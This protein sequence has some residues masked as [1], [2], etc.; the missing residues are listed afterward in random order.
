MQTVTELVKKEINVEKG[1]G[2]P[3]KEKIGNLAMEILQKGH[4]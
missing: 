3:D 4:T 1:S 2:T